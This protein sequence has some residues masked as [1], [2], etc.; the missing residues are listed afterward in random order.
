M[1]I[2]PGDQSGFRRELI[3]SGVAQ[4]VL[5]V[6]YREYVNDF[7]RPAFTQELKY[8]LSAGS[9]IGYRGA[10]LEIIH[11]GNTSVRF[12]LLKPMDDV[13]SNSLAR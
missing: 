9:E 8:D 1:K 5:S 6:S 12:K 7:A 3:Y 2:E 13:T 11:A 10:R 4:G